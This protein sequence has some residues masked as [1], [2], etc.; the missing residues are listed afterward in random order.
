MYGHDNNNLFTYTPAEALGHF[1]STTVMPPLTFP[2]APF[3]PLPLIIADKLAGTEFDSVMKSEVGSSSGCSSYGSPSS[4]TSYFTQKPSLIQRSVSSH[5][6]QKNGFC[7]PVSAGTELL[8]SETGPVRRVFSTGD[9]QQGIIMVQHTH[10]RSESPLSYES[11]SIIEGMS[12][13]CRYSPE[14][15]KERIERYRSK[16]TQR[17]FNKKIKYACRK[18][19][20]DSRP[21]IR[22]RFARNDEI[23]KISPAQWSHIG[24][25][26]DDEDEDNWANFLDAL[27]ANLI[28]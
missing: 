13:A 2:S 12:K 21:R 16:R 4:L 11:N 24:G 14:E 20:A 19:L 28:P 5:S 1:P 26:E 18:T 6:F 15:K 22:G 17:N 7:P 27:S 10:P 3:P 23:E 25:D 9:L 8:E